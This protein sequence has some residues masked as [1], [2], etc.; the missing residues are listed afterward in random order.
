MVHSAAEALA[1]LGV[2]AAADADEIR[3]AFRRHA[4][5]AHPDAGGNADDFARLQAAVTLLL[6]RPERPRPAASPSTDATFRPSTDATMTGTAWGEATGA[7]WHASSVDTTD[8]DWSANAPGGSFAWTTDLLAIELARTDDLPVR[9]VTGRS[10]RPGAFMNRFAGA[11]SGDLL[12]SFSIA[13][14]SGRGEPGHDVV[15][16]LHT[17]PGRA[18]RV[19]DDAQ[20]PLGWMR[21]RRPD[22]TVAT[23]L[24]H[25]SRDRRATAVRAARRLEEALAAL[26]WPLA[27]WRCSG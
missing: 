26:D 15:I 18:R 3:R 27:Q 2:G 6:D 8:V 10:R 1:V 14:A 11:I 25:P 19:L 16:T 13:P 4:R 9:A 5:T 20:L 23:L 7:R 22:S 21:E 12:A 17:P 24:L